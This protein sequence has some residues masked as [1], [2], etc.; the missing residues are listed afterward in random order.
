MQLQYLRH[1]SWPQRR[2]EG[3]RDDDIFEDVDEFFDKSLVKD[4]FELSMRMAQV[5][6]STS[7]WHRRMT[8]ENLSQSGQHLQATFTARGNQQRQESKHIGHYIGPGR[9]VRHIG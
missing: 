9:I 7:E 1:A 8:S 5:T 4:Q 2:A 3:G 6:R